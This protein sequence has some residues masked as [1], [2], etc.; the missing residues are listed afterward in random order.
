[1]TGP[2]LAICGFNLICSGGW[3]GGEQTQVLAVNSPRGG[4]GSRVSFTLCRAKF[5]QQEHSHSSTLPPQGLSPPGSV[6][7]LGAPWRWGTAMG[8]PLCKGLAAKLSPCMCSM[9]ASVH[10]LHVHTRTH[11]YMYTCTCMYAHMRAYQ[12]LQTFSLHWNSVGSR[13]HSSKPLKA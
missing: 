4:T 1:M 11:T 2:V 12:C 10:T 9:H 5:L 8:N 3:K 6:L 13:A 7:A